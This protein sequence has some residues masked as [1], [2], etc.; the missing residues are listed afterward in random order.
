MKAS[1]KTAPRKRVELG[2]Y[3]V[4]DSGICHGKPTFKGSRVMVWQV[5]RAIER[6]EDW[7]TICAAWRGSVTHEAIAEAV[8]LAGSL[9]TTS[10]DV[11]HLAR[12][13]LAE[14]GSPAQTRLRQNNSFLFPRL[15]SS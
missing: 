12:A 1:V 4:A 10:A 2:K 13:V 3:I 9:F 15:E 7:D 5:L 8:H 6:G 14:A 11:R